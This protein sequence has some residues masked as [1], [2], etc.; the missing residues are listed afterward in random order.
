MGYQK[1][2][3]VEY[4]MDNEDEDWLHAYNGAG[5]GV[6]ALPAHKCVRMALCGRAAHM[7]GAG[8]R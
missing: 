2:A 6:P 8:Q 5:G 4:D 7:M 3:W 1:D